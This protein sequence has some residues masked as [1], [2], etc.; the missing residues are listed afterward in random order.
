ML[1]VNFLS[2]LYALRKIIGVNGALNA[3]MSQAKVMQNY[4]KILFNKYGDEYDIIHTHGCFPYTS[5]LLKR[6]LKSKKPAILSLHQNHHDIDQSFLFSKPLSQIFKLYLRRY[7]ALS[8]LI[9][10]PTKYSKQIVQKELRITKPIKLISNGIETRK[11]NYSIEKRKNFRKR[12]G[13][14]KQTILSVGM[15]TVRK[16]FFDFIQFSRRLKKLYFMWVGVRAFPIIQPN[17]KINSKNFIMPGFV[18]DIVSAYS[19]CDIFC[20]PSYYEGEGIAI[21]EALSC[22]LPIIIR[23]LP[24]YDGRFTDGY[25]C[26]KARTNKEF[27]ENIN[28]LLDNPDE[29]KRIAKNGLKTAKKFDIK[30]TGKQIFELY[31]ELMG[32]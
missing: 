30:N 31:M 8:D 6:G 24:V 13:L 14:N 29:R 12:Y 32:S 23:D 10:C 21:L 1:K 3:T 15:P 9:I 27:I 11:I 22:G 4:V 25:N 2:D 28:F 20:F 5:H 16:G 19:G 26:L 17:Y 18:E 7:C